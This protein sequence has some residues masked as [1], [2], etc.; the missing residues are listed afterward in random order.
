MPKH[1]RDEELR[2]GD[3]VECFMPYGSM[4]GRLCGIY[5]GEG[6]VR[7]AAGSVNSVTWGLDN[8]RLVKRDAN[9]SSIPNKE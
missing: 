8:M 9:A 1:D 3:T 2:I 5:E 4:T 6:W 7:S